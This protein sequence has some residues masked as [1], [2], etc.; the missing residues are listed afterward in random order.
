[1]TGKL[2]KMTFEHHPD[3]TGTLEYLAGNRFLCTYSDPTFGIKAIPFEIENSQVKSLRLRV[4][5]FV[6]FIDYK[7][8]MQ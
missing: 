4:A 1:M 8:V 2:L 7:F 5:D 3:L 6:E